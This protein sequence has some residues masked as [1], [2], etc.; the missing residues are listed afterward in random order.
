MPADGQPLPQLEHN[1]TSS[2]L[3]DP[4]AVALMSVTD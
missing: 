1:G 3:C 2:P 4:C